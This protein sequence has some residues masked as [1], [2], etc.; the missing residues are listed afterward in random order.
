[1]III[2]RSVGDKQLRVYRFG[3]G[4]RAR[5]V[6]AGTHGPDESPDPS[7][8]ERLIA[9]LDNNPAA[10]P[11]EVTVYIVQSLNP[12]SASTAPQP[13]GLW[14]GH[15]VDLNRN[16][17]ADWKAAWENTGCA[18]DP[19][20]AGP[21]PASEPETQALLEFIKTRG[22]EMLLHY[23]HSRDGVFPAGDPPSPDA[24]A[25]AK[26]LAEALNV[27]SGQDNKCPTNGMLTAWAAGYGLLAV[28][29]YP[30]NAG[31]KAV[32]RN[33]D[34]LNVFLTWVVAAPPILPPTQ[35]TPAATRPYVTPT[36]L[37]TFTP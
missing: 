15:G 24:E 33:I 2:G 13:N 32:R 31:E 37:P 16:F 34:A 22:I 9:Y 21:A 5:L 23:N 11:A 6:V 30:H 36:F 1:V 26:A 35:G 27:E 17:D 14:N 12:D 8:A 25:L 18:I 3:S 7:L 19:G 28:D 20:G 4:P 29:A 10:V